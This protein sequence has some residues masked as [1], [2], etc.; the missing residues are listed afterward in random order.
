[1]DC[2]M[3]VMDGYEATQKIREYFNAKE[4]P[5]PI[6]IAVTGH[7]EN[8]YVQRAISSGMNEVSAKP[9]DLKLIE[10]VLIKLKYV[11]LN[12]LWSGSY[13]I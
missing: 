5:Q 11:N 1:M 4:L 2:Q 7:C 8:S 6:I 3:P 10:D 12:E 9:V 13:Y